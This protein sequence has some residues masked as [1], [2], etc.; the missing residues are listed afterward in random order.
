MIGWE[1]LEMM[2][3]VIFWDV[4]LLLSP[5][6]MHTYGVVLTGLFALLLLFHLSSYSSSPPT[7]LLLLLP[8]SSYS[9][10]PPAPLPVLFR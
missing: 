2:L 1:K 6:P 4:S 10:S 9:S 7:P 8:F 5:L 3:L